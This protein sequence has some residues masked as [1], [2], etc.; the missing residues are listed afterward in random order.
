MHHQITPPTPKG[1]H[2]KRAPILILLSLILSYSYSQQNL[3]NIPSGDITNEKKSFYQHQINLYSIKLESKA[4]FVHGLGKGWDVGLNIVGK[5]A[6][7]SPAWRISYN[8]NPSKGALYPIILATAQKQFTITDHIEFNIGTQA[9]FN[10][11]NRLENKELN[12]FSYGIGVWHF[13]GHK[14]RIVGGLYNTNRMYVGQGNTFGVM[15]GYEVRVSER[16]YLMGDWISGDNDAAVSVIGATYN[17]TRRLQL[18]AG[19]Q[20]PNPGTL[21]PSGLVLEL[22]VL[23]W[24]NL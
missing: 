3:F 13:M 2:L 17:L 16:W 15:A 24:D 20:V 23:G 12:H 18:C 7:F 5:G 21:K 9:G 6:Y 19:W 14:G 1:C 10:I 8:D 11:S 4:H 22:N